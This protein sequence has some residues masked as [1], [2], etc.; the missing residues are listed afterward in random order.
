MPQFGKKPELVPVEV[1]DGHT[2]LMHPTA[3][4]PLGEAAN[5][6]IKHA[7]TE[8]DD[9]QE[10]EDAISR[11]LVVVYVRFGVADWDYLDEH[12]RKVPRTRENMDAVLADLPVARAIAAKGDELY[13]EAVL[14]PLRELASKS[15]QAS[16][17]GKSTPR[18]RR[19]SSKRPRS[20]GPSTTSSTPPSP[21]TS[22]PIDGASS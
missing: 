20:S 21:P 14:A 1:P 13:S 6:A 2:V 7:V 4:L 16:R 10:Q 3:T 18:S 9:P 17:S 8:Y 11:V 12:G 15:R 22:A 5:Q 19:S